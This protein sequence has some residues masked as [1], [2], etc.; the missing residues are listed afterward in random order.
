MFKKNVLEMKNNQLVTVFSV[1]LC[2]LCVSVLK[3]SIFST[4]TQRTQRNTEFFSTI[5][6]H[7]TLYII[8]LLLMVTTVAMAQTE[9][10]AEEYRV[11]DETLQEKI[12][13]CFDNEDYK[14]S[15]KILYEAIALFNQLSKEEQEN[16]KGYQ[17]NNYYNLACIYSLQKQTKKAVDAFEKAIIT[18]GYTDYQHAKTDTDLDNI[19]TEK[20][21]IAL[22]ESIR[23]KGDY[24]YILR[25]AGKYQQA[26]TTGLPHFT[27]EEAT[28]YNLKNVKEFFKLDSIAGEGDEISKI[29]NLMTWVHDNIGHHNSYAL[30]EFTSIDIYNYS[31]S[32]GKGV[33]CR[34]LAITLNEMYL[35]MGIKSRYVTC[36]PKDS[37]DSD[38]HVINNVYSNTLKKWLWMDPSFNAYIKD[39]NDN[40]LSIAE[41]RERMIDGRPLVLNKEA[42]YNAKNETTKEWY[43]DYYMAKNL[44]WFNCVVNTQFNTES[45][46]RWTKQTYV[47]LCPMGFTPS[48]QHST[49]VITNDPVYFWEHE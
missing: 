36:M 48:E 11:Q 19:R 42:N 35:A 18:Y 40:L 8:C 25:Q 30:C 21:F 6:N 46:Y 45:R 7:Y 10:S 34:H 22:M 41:V 4:E 33:N 9:I 31:K 13:E 37:T 3:K 24:I 47:S 2:A 5:I 28:N 43:L 14:T 17:E 26:D 23:E 1:H 38:C 29:I 15:E 12:L 44:Y 20:R 32:N 16:H 49:Q 27:Y 39:E